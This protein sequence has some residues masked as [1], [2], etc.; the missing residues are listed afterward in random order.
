MATGSFW[1]LDDPAKP[2]G[3]M[4]PD[5][6]L[7]VPYDFSE[8]LADQGTA[9][10]SHNLDA[11][12]G[13]QAVTVSPDAGVITIQVQRAPSGVLTVGQKYGVTCQVVAAD[14]QKRSKT[15]YYK[16]KEQ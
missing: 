7:N 4:D 5:D 8:W 10:A 16:I 9:Y 3:L 12:D 1:N 13:L 11:A 15:L 14:G 6:V 2:W